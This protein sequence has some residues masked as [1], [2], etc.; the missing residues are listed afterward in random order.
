VLL[1]VIGKNWNPLTDS[2]QRRLSDPNDHLGIEIETALKRK[3]PVIPVLVDGVK[4]PA[5][6]ELPQAL[7]GLV[8]YNGVMVRP[9]PDFHHDMDRLSRAIKKLF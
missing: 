2:G 8:Y 7:A 1:A 5:A 6:H 4:M 9:D 3:I